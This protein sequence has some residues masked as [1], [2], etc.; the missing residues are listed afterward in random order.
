MRFGAGVGSEQEVIKAF[1]PGWNVEI[2]AE[3]V[4]WASWRQ[5]IQKLG[6]GG[7]QQLGQGYSHREQPPGTQCRGLACMH[8]SRPAVPQLSMALAAPALPLSGEGADLC[9][10]MLSEPEEGHAP[11]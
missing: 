5:G 4:S 11:L 9:L 3:L 10:G 1:G 8:S 6:V 2:L 7:S